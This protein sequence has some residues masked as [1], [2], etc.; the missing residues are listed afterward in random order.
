MPASPREAAATSTL[1]TECRRRGWLAVRLVPTKKGIPDWLLLLPEGR[2]VFVELKRERGGEL[3]KIQHHIH[4]GYRSLGHEV[5][6]PE[7]SAEV[8]ALCASLV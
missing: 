5:Y 2:T 6:V 1:L 7:G 4:D 3:S 8:K